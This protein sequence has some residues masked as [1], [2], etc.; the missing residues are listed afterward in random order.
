MNKISAYS[1]YLT[2]FLGFDIAVTCPKCSKKATIKSSHFSFQEANQTFK[3]T[4]GTC[5]FSKPTLCKEY[6]FGGPF[7]PFFQMSLW[8]QTTFGEHTIWAF[9]VEHLRFLENHVAAKLRSRNGLLPVIIY[10]IKELLR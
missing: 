10:L 2:N 8:Y 9:N 6:I 3:V 7:D 1:T 4:C 5:G